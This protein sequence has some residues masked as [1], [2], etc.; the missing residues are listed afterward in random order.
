MMSSE[1]SSSRVTTHPPFVWRWIPTLLYPRLLSIRNAHFKRRSGNCAEKVSWVMTVL[2]MWG[3]YRLTT[4]GLHEWSRLPGAEAVPLSTLL[5][6]LFT[7]LCAMIFLSSCV[8]A[9]SCLYM[10]KDIELVLSSP[11][12]TNALLLGKV[13]EVGIASS[14]M[15][16]T[17]AIP[18]YLSFG[19]FF[20]AG[21]LYYSLAPVVGL[22]V[23]VLTTLLGTLTA[24]LFT[25]LLPIRG[26]IRIFILFVFLALSFVFFALHSDT[27]MVF[28]RDVRRYSAAHPLLAFMRPFHSTGLAIE[29][30]LSDKL[31]PTLFV[32]AAHLASVGVAWLAL[33]V[34]FSQLF[35]SS[36]S[37]IHSKGLRLQFPSRFQLDWSR[38]FFPRT[39]QSIRAL[40]T[41]DFYSFSRD[42]AHTVQLCMLLAI[43][44]LYLY[45]FKRIEPPTRVSPETLRAWDV[46]MIL[47]NLSLGSMV[48][49]SICSRFIFPAISLEGSCMWIVQAA[50]VSNK[51]FLKAKYAGWILP[52]MI[53]SGVIFSSGSL[54]IGLEPFLAA[55]TTAC[56]I[57]ITHGLV[58]LAIGLGAR[59][60]RFDWEHVTQLTTS[61][62]N[63]FYMLAGLLLV[64]LNLLPISVMYGAYIFFPADFESSQALC[65]LFGSGLAS[66]LAINF[67]VGRCAW[68]LGARRMRDIG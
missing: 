20:H 24:I 18:L 30:I 29:A 15:L 27:F 47:A 43:C 31:G 39:A 65:A 26:G 14:W 2:M 68:S 44:V 50:P 17:F 1:S 67:I 59:F 35:Q 41:K 40:I 46:F 7:G 16:C 5:G 22:C 34:S 38:L 8:S 60:A 12:T 25:A 57:A 4:D 66:I 56:G 53:I 11:I 61:S 52:T 23:L 55:T 19:I 64:A 28:I 9:I 33:Q 49:L 42:L 63:L 51:D 62:G 21:L 54:A 45:N 13:M 37:R 36:Y 3:L 32:I 10:S 48:V 58:A 6:A